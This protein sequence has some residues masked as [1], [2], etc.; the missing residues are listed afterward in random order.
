M[1]NVF[2]QM[3]YCKKWTLLVVFL[4][5]NIVKTR[6]AQ[7]HVLWPKVK[8]KFFSRDVNELCESFAPEELYCMLYM[9]I[10]DISF[11]QLFNLWRLIAVGPASSGVLVPLGSWFLWI[12]TSLVSNKSQTVQDKTK[13]F[14]KLET[15]GSGEENVLTYLKIFI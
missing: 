2:I 15:S 10:Y 7:C 4:I 9:Y 13:P 14:L 5:V 12:Y 6:Q 11:H 8:A 3:S 1:H